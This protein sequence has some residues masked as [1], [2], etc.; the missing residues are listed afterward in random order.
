MEKLIKSAQEAK[1]LSIEIWTSLSKGLKRK[2]DLPSELFYRI[3]KL[4]VHCPLCEWFKIDID[5]TY[6]D[7]FGK[8]RYVCAIDCS[9]CPLAMAGHKCDDAPK[10]ICPDC[11]DTKLSICENCFN[12]RDYYTQWIAAYDVYSGKEALEASNHAAEGILNIIK[13]WEV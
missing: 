12:S 5:K 10:V 13:D 2:E 1:D 7:R 9:K 11:E 8:E 4:H 3:K 6:I